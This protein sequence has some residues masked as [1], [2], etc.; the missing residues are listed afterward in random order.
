MAKFFLY[1]PYPLEKAFRIR[2]LQITKYTISLS[3]IF[4]LTF[5]KEGKLENRGV[6]KICYN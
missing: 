2:P 3:L 6:I 4:D 1:L 5:S